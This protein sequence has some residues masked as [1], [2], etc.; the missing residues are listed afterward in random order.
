[1]RRNCILK[2]VIDG[3][4]RGRIEMTRKY[5]RRRK[6]LLDDLEERDDTEN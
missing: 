6:Q 4:I 2:H 5:G 3:K 1:V